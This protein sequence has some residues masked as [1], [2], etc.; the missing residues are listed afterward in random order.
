MPEPAWDVQVRA[1]EQELTQ[2]VRGRNEERVAVT[3]V[4]EDVPEQ[5]NH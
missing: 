5:K 2:S 3:I 4:R 1:G